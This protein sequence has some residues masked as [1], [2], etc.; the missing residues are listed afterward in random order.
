MHLVSFGKWV[1]Q[2]LKLGIHQVKGLP[3]KLKVFTGQAHM[4]MPEKVS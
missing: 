2:F 4:P 3:P 1:C